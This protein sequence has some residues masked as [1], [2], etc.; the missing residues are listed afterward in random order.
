MYQSEDKHDIGPIKE[1]TEVFSER[2]SNGIET[3][4]IFKSECDYKKSEESDYMPKVHDDSKEDNVKDNKAMMNLYDGHVTK[5][6]NKKPKLHKISNTSTKLHKHKTRS[7]YDNVATVYSTSSFHSLTNNR[8]T[9]PDVVYPSH[10][11][12]SKQLRDDVYI[13]EII[14]HHR[15]DKKYKDNVKKNMGDYIKNVYEDKPIRSRKNKRQTRDL[16]PDF[17]ADIIRRQYKPIKMFGRKESDL[18]QFSAPVCRDQEFS[19]QENI[20]EDPDLCSCFYSGRHR[21]TKPR[22]QDLNGMQSVC[23]ARLYSSKKQLRHK[24]RRM[25]IDA[26]SNS[27]MYDL[28]PVKERTSP[29][30]RR[31]F[32]ESNRF[33]YEYYRE[34]PPSPRTLR[35]KLNL[36]AQYYTELEDYMAYNKHLRKHSPKR[37]KRYQECLE[38]F[39]SDMVSEVVPVNS[40]RNIPQQRLPQKFIKVPVEDKQVQEQSQQ[41][42]G[43]MSSLQ[44][45]QYANEQTSMTIDT[46]LNKTQETELNV[47]K[48]DKALCE[49]KDILQTFLHEIKKDTVASQCDKSDITHECKTQDNESNLLQDPNVKLNSN[50]LP[51]SSSFNN[52]SVGQCGM[53]P[54][55]APFT[56][57]C[58][59]PV[60]PICPMNCPLPVP[61]GYLVPSQSFT[62][63]NC[64]NAPKETNSA[65]CCNKNIDASCPTETDELI[66]EIYKFVARSPTRK[67]NNDRINKDT[68][69][70]IKHVDSKIMTSRSAGG[71]CKYFQQDANVGTQPLKCYSKSCEALGSRMISDPYYSG[72]NASYSDTLLEKLSLEATTQSISETELDTETT[73]P[74]KVFLCLCSNL[75]YL[76]EEHNF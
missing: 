50:I 53:G 17:I 11:N 41:D 49:I 35:P 46:S 60:M 14:P 61:N 56:N 7:A 13:E 65:H 31:K 23:D 16:D 40:D 1:Q 39:E 54:Y 62:C 43:T 75:L 19:L 76:L 25:H 26:Y 59:Y 24:L 2:K 64:V 15:K 38:Q 29:K 72:T 10:S 57:P 8:I 73:D 34:V 21:R 3:Q 20:Q 70:E 74:D 55:I 32:V 33:P 58:C 63:T 42:N 69:H 47:D 71:S 6:K 30:T 37:Q 28:V 4:L 27:D 52:Y 45:P 48:T 67:N 36:K 68:T 22:C 44:Y 12:D 18:S 66:K 5:V 51:N 9:Q